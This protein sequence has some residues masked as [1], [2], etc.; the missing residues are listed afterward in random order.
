MTAIVIGSR[1]LQAH[2]LLNPSIRRKAWVQSAAI[3]CVI[4][5]LTGIPNTSTRCGFVLS[6]FCAI[7][8]LITTNGMQMSLDVAG[9]N[10]QPLIVWITS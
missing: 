6:P 2:I 3:F 4:T 9:I 8:V 1:N 7:H 10:H 5:T